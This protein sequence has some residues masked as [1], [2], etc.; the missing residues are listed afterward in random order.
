MRLSPPRPSTPAPRSPAGWWANLLDAEGNPALRLALQTREQHIRRRQGH[1]Q[2]LP[3]QVLLAV[4]ASSMPCT[5]GPDGLAAIRRRLC[6]CSAP[7]LPWGLERWL[8][9]G[10]RSGLDTLQ[11]AAPGCRQPCC[12][13]EAA[14]FNL[15]RCSLWPGHQASM[16]AP[17][18]P[19]AGSLAGRFL[20]RPAG[21][22]ARRRLLAEA[23]SAPPPLLG[24]FARG[25]LVGASA[26]A[27]RPLLNQEF[28]IATAAKPSSAAALTIQRLVSKDLS[29]G[30]R[31]DPAGQLHDEAQRRRPSWRP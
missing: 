8:W 5:T 30:A 11:P 10:A 19:R 2:H 26:A 16:S 17:T 9:R 31:I 22:R 3:A 20:R 28:S 12:G 6:C 29:L 13:A 14:G 21:P 15:R 25:H 4:M 27:A 18:P 1:Q 23:G 7:A 24:P